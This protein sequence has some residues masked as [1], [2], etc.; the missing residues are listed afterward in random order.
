MTFI[1]G[2][3]D[4]QEDDVD[5]E[6]DREAAD[7]AQQV[8]DAAAAGTDAAADGATAAVEAAADGGGGAGDATVVAAGQQ[9]T[10]RYLFPGINAPLPDGA[11][12]D[13]WGAELDK[14]KFVAQMLGVVS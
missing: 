11:D 4:E 5:A 6:A 14:A 10:S 2:S 12:A 7:G 13:A 1:T 3:D 9:Q 8:G